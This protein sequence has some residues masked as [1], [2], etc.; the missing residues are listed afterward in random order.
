M[1]KLNSRLIILSGIFMF[2][3]FSHKAFG[4]TGLPHESSMARQG[5]FSIT[6]GLSFDVINNKRIRL[7]KNIFSSYG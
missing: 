7:Y 6:P 4:E 1:T 3:L 5:I 2:E